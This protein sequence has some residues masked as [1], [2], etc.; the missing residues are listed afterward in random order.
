[1]ILTG[2]R[3]CYIRASDSKYDQRW[4][5]QAVLLPYAY[6][7]SLYESLQQIHSSQGHDH[8]PH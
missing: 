7:L 6:S 5:M 1:M 8:S 4:A 3:S 2:L